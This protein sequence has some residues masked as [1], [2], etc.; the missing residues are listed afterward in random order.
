MLCYPSNAAAGEN[1][2]VDVVPVHS[3]SVEENRDMDYSEV[4]EDP[5]GQEDEVAEWMWAQK[6][7]KVPKKAS[8]K[9]K[10]QKLPI[11]IGPEEESGTPEPGS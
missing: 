7:A 11:D 8:K 9:A 1:M 5:G 2:I 3:D 4:N 6:K 10:K